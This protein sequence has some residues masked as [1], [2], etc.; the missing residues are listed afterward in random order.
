MSTVL[1][2]S[3]SPAMAQPSGSSG[4][5][6]SP[7]AQA[8]QFPADLQTIKPGQSIQASVQ[9][10]HVQPGQKA[11]LIQVQTAIGPMSLQTTLTVPKGAVLSLVL[12]QS[13]PQPTLV[14]ASIN[15][16]PV[17]G[18]QAAAQSAQAGAA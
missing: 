5:S 17:P 13:G 1:P 7:T 11:T 3:T 18:A 12:T 6:A 2:P 15:G 10:I 14:I 16:Q 9:S 8:V 4:S